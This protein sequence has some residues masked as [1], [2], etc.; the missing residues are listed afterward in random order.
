MEVSRGG[1]V[2]LLSKVCIGFPKG[3]EGFRVPGC[4]PGDRL[5]A[6]GPINY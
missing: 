6:R 1:F 2:S 3:F 4:A 5:T